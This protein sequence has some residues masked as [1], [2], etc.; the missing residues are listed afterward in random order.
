MAAKDDSVRKEGMKAQRAINLGAWSAHRGTLLGRQGHI[1]QS[2]VV[3]AR[4]QL[5]QLEH[6]RPLVHQEEEGR[7]VRI[8][9]STQRCG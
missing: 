1:E 7:P 5:L 4:Q 3:E 8:S 6:K 9:L 2:A